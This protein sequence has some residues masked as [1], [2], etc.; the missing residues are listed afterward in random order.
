MISTE[1]QK[2]ITESQNQNQFIVA[3]FKLKEWADVLP[4]FEQLHKREITGT[5]AVWQWL[6]DRSELDALLEE[7]LAWR[8]I[9]MTCNTA[10]EEAVK[11]YTYFIEEIEPQV[12]KFQ[13]DLDVK[14][15]Q[16]ADF[17]SINF[18]G[19]DIFR[20]NVKKDLEIF[21]EENIPLQTEI[22]NKAQEYAA[23]SGALTIEW[24]GEELTMP[25][26]GIILQSTDREERKLVYEKIQNR[27]LLDA[28]KLEGI[29]SDLVKLRHAVSINADFSNFRDYMFKSMGRFDY[30]PAD[31]KV[32]H[33]AVETAVLP[34]V[35]KLAERRKQ[36]L[37]LDLLKPFD[38]AVEENGK[39]PL[40]AFEGGEDLLNKGKEVFSKLDPFLGNCLKAMEEKGHFDLESRKGKA[41][42]GYNY[43]LDQTGFPF[44]FMNASSSLRDMVTLMH[45]GGHAVHSVVTRFLP[46]SF[47]KHT[48]SEVAELASMSMELMTMDYWD[49]YFQNPDELKRAKKD[50]LVQV[51]DTLPWV[52]TIDAFQHWLY[53]NPE[54]TV[55]ERSQAWLEVSGRFSSGMVDYTG[56]EHFKT[57]A[58][59]KQLHLFEVPFYYVEYGMAQLGAISV[60]R[61]YKQNPEKALTQYLQ[62]LSLGHTAGIREVYE[63][64]GVNFDFSESYI[65]ELMQFV[66]AEM[67][68]L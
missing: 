54:H 35:Q 17:D 50:H 9:K 39:A 46:L 13:N 52:A 4:Y 24:R 14:L 57:I 66:W 68:G 59:H 41:P 5:D 31:C 55:E 23:I 28:E 16:T 27:R 7:D 19:A 42:G 26:A 45:E 3:D 65:S 62:A 25:R 40:K 38:L 22:Q 1:Y 37:G 15:N 18:A 58:W 29:F 63:T 33:K 49:V 60:W 67:E 6:L 44:I 21:R 8:Y 48:S 47:F 10:D 56:Y 2:F 61:N 36:N 34:L 32:F 11:S 53:E 12:A 20:K 43:P 64:A 30:T 51:I